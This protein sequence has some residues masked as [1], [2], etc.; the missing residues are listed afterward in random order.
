MEEHFFLNRLNLSFASE[1]QE[2]K[3]LF[4]NDINYLSASIGLNKWFDKN[5]W[6]TAKYAI[7][8]EAIP[9]LANNISNVITAIL[10]ISKKCLVLDLDNTCWGG[11]IGDDG[12]NGIK[13]GN[14]T[15]EGE[16]YLAF[17]KYVKELKD[18]GVILAVCSKNE[19]DNAK[20]GFT[21]SDSVLTYADFT[22]FYANWEPKHQNIEKIAQEINID[23]GSLVFIDDNAM[24]RNLVESHLSTVSVPDVGKNVLNFIDYIEQNGYFSIASLSDDDIKRNKFYSENQKRTK[25]QTAFKNYDDFLSSL[26]MEAEIKS[27]T[28]IYFER[29]TQLIN[30]TN[31]F[32]LTTKRYA[33]TDV[34][35]M[36]KS[37]DFITLFGKLTDKFG[38]NGLISVVVGK[39]EKKKCI[40]DT[41]L[42]SCRVLKRD[43]E[44]AMLNILIAECSK[45]N[46]TEIY[47]QYKR[48]AKNNMVANLYGDMGFELIESNEAEGLW[49]LTIN[50]FNRKELTIKIN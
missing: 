12:L 23:I 11:V 28:D 18:R 27:F 16:A 29:I 35:A 22:S 45:R 37:D 6:F 50:N 48:T 41:W 3:S 7:S 32:N 2:N 17:Q 15:P 25:E 33:I 9:A 42:M 31:Q 36:A 26:L 47:G 39:I 5:L 49:K 30:K 1:A 24:E 4:I 19:I 8:F 40:I 14:E 46:L 34:E 13:L 44:F 38:D 20:E 21:H 43:M 10:G